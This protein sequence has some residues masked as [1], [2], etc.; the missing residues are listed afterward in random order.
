MLRRGP[1]TSGFVFGVGVKGTSH[2]TCMTAA[3]NAATFYNEGGRVAE[4]IKH[5]L[6]KQVGLRWIQGV[7]CVAFACEMRY[8]FIGIVDVA[9]IKAN[10]DVYI[11]E[12]KASSSDMRSD[13]KDKGRRSPKIYRIQN[14]S[15][16]DF[17]YYIVADTVTV[18]D[19]F[20]DFIGIIDES[21]RVQKRATR[22]VRP[23]T[24]QLTAEDLGRFARVCSWR[25]YGH[26][27]RHEQ[28]QLEFSIGG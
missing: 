26:V 6:L 27:I 3:L 25:A 18:P 12:A 23:R 4:G 24:S 22:R 5:K 15:V 7:G 11:V 1:P 21:G 16:V 2:T 8:D 9:G 17:V 19:H 28:E 13:M 10:G 14:C 20:P